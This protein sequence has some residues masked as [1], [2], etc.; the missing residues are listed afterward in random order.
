MELHDTIYKALTSL[1]YAAVNELWGY[2]TFYRAP[3]IIRKYSPK[4][5]NIVG[6][7]AAQ[8][9][10]ANLMYKNDNKTG[11]QQK[12]LHMNKM[13]HIFGTHFS[14]KFLRRKV[15]SLLMAKW[16]RELAL[17][18]P[19]SIHQWYIFGIFVNKWG[20]RKHIDNLKNTHGAV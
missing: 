1:N 7:P 9:T 10:R 17:C 18:T 14:N 6:V 15:T 16:L 8:H 11:Q 13:L 12:I 20:T 19:L 2:I 4:T 3:L 5:M